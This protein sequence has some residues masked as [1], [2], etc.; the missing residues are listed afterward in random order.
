MQGKP[1]K[2]KW[3]NNLGRFVFQKKIEKMKQRETENEVGEVLNSAQ[4]ELEVT[5]A[6]PLTNS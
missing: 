3:R 2:T 6:I 5:R 4:S 1:W